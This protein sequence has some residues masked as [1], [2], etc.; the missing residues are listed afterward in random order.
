M[1]IFTLPAKIWAYITA[2]AMLITN[3]V[4]IGSATATGDLELVKTDKVILEKAMY[5][6]QGITTD[7]EYYY[8]SGAM[9]AVNMT[10]LAKWNAE[11]F[12]LV[13]SK[14]NAVPDEYYELYESDH[15]GGISYYNGLIYASVENHPD[16]HP[17]VITYDCETLE[18][19]ET[20]HMPVEHLPNGI[21]WVA[22][23]AENGYLYCSPFRNVTK[24]PAFDLETMEFDHY[25]YL[26][27]EVTR[28][29]GGEVFEG[30]LYLSCDDGANTDTIRTVDVKTGETKLLS[31]RT[32]PG[33]NG[34]E[35]ED[36]TVFPMKDGSLFHVIDYDKT[37]GIYIRHYALD[38]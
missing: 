12:S 7:G 31:E 19:V 1:N 33:I 13:M 6:G 18:P 5:T 34:N 4:G 36:L 37:V 26:N 15:I 24:I 20:Y 32:L 27:D 22:V 3:I 8:T 10:G 21:P 29:Q 23:D 35:C 11:D 2:L 30:I 28:I 17:L 9:T 25:I 16:D 38:K 14:L